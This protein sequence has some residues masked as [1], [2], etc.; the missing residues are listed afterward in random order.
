MKHICFQQYESPAGTIIIGDYCGQICM[1]DWA[2]SRRH[3]RNKD[4]LT[5]ALNAQ[6][7]NRHT[8]LTERTLTQLNEYFNGQRREFDL[9]LLP[10]GSEFRK[11]VW[12]ALTGIGYGHTVTYAEIAMRINAPQS[13]RAVASAIG[14]NMISIIIPCHR[15]IGRSGSLTGYAGGLDA[16]SALL[17]LE[18]YSAEL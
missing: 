8:A 1:A 16:K 9:P 18:A 7:I 5:R 14:D 6:F 4:K 11:D 13:V 15:V 3:L 10:I 2:N 17:A 12:H